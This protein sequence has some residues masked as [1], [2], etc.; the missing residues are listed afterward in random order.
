MRY[1]GE[2]IRWTSR[3]PRGLE[4]VVTGSVLYCKGLHTIDLSD[5]QS[6]QLFPPV[7]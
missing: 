5:I 3:L 4:R 7:Y 2:R 6:V 1:Q